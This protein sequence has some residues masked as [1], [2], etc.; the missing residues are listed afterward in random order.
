M[1][2]KWTNIILE[3]IKSYFMHNSPVLMAKIHA[4]PAQQ[5]LSAPLQHDSIQTVVLL[6]FSLHAGHSTR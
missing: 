1:F 6:L 4:H 5:D 3:N 2:K